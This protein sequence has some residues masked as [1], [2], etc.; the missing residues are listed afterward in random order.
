MDFGSIYREAFSHPEYN[1]HSDDEPRYRWAMAAMDLQAWAIEGSGRKDRRLLWADVGSG[2]G[3]LLRMVRESGLDVLTFSI[4]VERFHDEPDCITVLLDL[5]EPNAAS[6]L[7]GI[8]P[9]DLLV[10]LDVLEHLPAENLDPLLAA[11]AALSRRVVVSVADHPESPYGTELHLT[12]WGPDAWEEAFGRHF[13]IEDRRIVQPNPES[14]P[15]F[16]YRLI[17][18]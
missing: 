10:C 8:G 1:R 12:R 6:R 18:S 5:T 13:D 7:R 16:L 15:S 17:R 9:V 4:D 14:N 2:R 3:H 11:F